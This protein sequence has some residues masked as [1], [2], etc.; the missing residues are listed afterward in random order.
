MVRQELIDVITFVGSSPI[1]DLDADNPPEIHVTT[2]EELGRL[3]VEARAVMNWRP[4]VDAVKAVIEHEK[5]HAYA[6]TVLGGKHHFALQVNR[7]S[8]TRIDFRP[9][10]KAE[11]HPLTSPIEQ[12]AMHAYPT[13]LSE[14]DV[15]HLEQLGYPDVNALAVQLSDMNAAHG[16]NLPIPLSYK[17]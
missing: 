9:I 11:L 3:I 13:E 10:T 5:Q 15:L 7:P 8:L 2:L 14:G 1:E 17:Q 16:Y 4:E 12:A 6:V